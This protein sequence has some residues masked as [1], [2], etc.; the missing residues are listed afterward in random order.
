MK[1]SYLSLR[2]TIIHYIFVD[3]RKILMWSRLQSDSASKR[4]ASDKNEDTCKVFQFR[5]I[6]G[7]LSI[8]LPSPFS[9]QTQDITMR[10]GLILFKVNELIDSKIELKSEIFTMQKLGNHQIE[11]KDGDKISARVLFT[12][13]LS[14]D[15][16]LSN[17]MDI[18]STTVR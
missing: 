8:I 9:T 17:I 16:L 5:N 12:Y 15:V 10:F 2:Q 18:T 1:K 13:K 14:K 7:I 3:F 11:C 6:K 4:W